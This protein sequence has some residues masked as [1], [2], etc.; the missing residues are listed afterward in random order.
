[1]YGTSIS[2]L[3]IMVEMIVAIPHIYGA[4]AIFLQCCDHQDTQSE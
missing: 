4:R 3:Y 1:M 2:T